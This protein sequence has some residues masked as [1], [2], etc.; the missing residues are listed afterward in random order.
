MTKTQCSKC[1]FGDVA[2]SD[3]PCE[4]NI[5]TKIK[6]IKN[7]T[8]IDDYYEIENYRCLYGF[9][10]NQYDQNIENLKDIDIY[11]LVKDKANI[12]YYMIL[13]TRQIS[14]DRIYEIINE[15]NSL[16]FKPRYLS[17][18]I[19]PNDPD[20]IYDYVRHNLSCHKWTIHVFVETLSFNNCINII[21]DTNL[22][23]SES[24]CLL[25]LD[26]NNLDKNINDIVNFMQDTFIVK[27]KS[28]YGIKNDNSLHMMCLNCMVYKTLVSTVDRDILKSI[29]STPEIILETYEIK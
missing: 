7:L 19:S 5:L 14:K 12:K 24:W 23:N 21:L 3:M 2:S 29:E 22:V 27:Q 26:A 8:V 15:I 13:D 17:I 10:K 18:I 11:K 25:F 1:I 20:P 28:F 6:D 16:E 4:F 9:S